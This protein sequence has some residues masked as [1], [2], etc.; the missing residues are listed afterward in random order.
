MDLVYFGKER[1]KRTARIDN[2]SGV[3]YVRFLKS[4]LNKV[5]PK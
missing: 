1:E 2:H 5:N 3:M 4:Q